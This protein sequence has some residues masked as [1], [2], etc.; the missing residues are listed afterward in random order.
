M[1]NMKKYCHRHCCVIVTEKSQKYFK[2]TPYRSRRRRQKAGV[3]IFDPGEQR[4]LLV[5]SRGYLWGVPKGS[6]EPNESITE[7]AIR[8]VKEETGISLKADELSRELTLFGKSTYYYT[9]RKTR[10]VKVQKNINE[11]A[12]DV[13]GIT[14]IKINCLNNL[15]LN[16]HL[17]ILLS[18]YLKKV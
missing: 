15:K 6:I 3:F 16:K 13:N 7:C 2:H 11:D 4:I 18:V 8:E 1:K 17:Q 12:N 10:G 9:E 14:W 5:R